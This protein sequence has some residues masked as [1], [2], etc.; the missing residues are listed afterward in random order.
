MKKQPFRLKRQPPDR[1]IPV[2]E[3]VR[4]A[5]IFK[6]RADPRRP[7]S[8]GFKCIVCGKENWHSAENGFRSAG[9]PCW[10]GDYYVELEK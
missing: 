9:C 1:W 10:G 7:N 4:F 6:C 5:P 2:F 3:A 8:M